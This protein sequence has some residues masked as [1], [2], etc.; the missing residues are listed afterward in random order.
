M[1]IQ[2]IDEYAEELETEI[3]YLNMIID[4]LIKRIEDGEGNT[5][6]CLECLEPEFER[7]NTRN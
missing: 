6:I 3:E 2:Y 4:V 1:E 7:L 5:C